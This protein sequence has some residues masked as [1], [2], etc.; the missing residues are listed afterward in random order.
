MNVKKYLGVLL[1]ILVTILF[2]GF[3]TFNLLLTVASYV[4]NLSI[5]LISFIHYFFFWC[6]K[7]NVMNVK[8]YLG[9]LLFILVTILFTGCSLQTV[10]LKIFSDFIKLR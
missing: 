9:V 7:L 10:S 2:T 3:I 6:I 4:Q 5:S 8:K 1:F